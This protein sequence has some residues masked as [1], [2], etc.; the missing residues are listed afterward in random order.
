[1]K[2]VAQTFGRD[3]INF[4]PADLLGSNSEG[5]TKREYFAALALQAMI[6]GPHV[7][8]NKVYTAV[9]YADLLIAELNKETKP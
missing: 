4:V 8:D 7:V 3:P 2:H 1:M 6:I 9:H 5:L